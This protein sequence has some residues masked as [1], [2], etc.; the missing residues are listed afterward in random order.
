MVREVI[1]EK[2]VVRIEEV[3]YLVITPTT[4]LL[5]YYYRI[6]EVP[7]SPTTSYSPLLTWYPLPTIHYSLQQQLHND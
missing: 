3:R 7:P 2:E 6:E 5:P 1:I 4:V